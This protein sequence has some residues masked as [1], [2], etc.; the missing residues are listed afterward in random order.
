MN[1]RWPRL[2]ACVAVLSC[3]TIGFAVA[4]I[5]DDPEPIAGVRDVLDPI[6]PAK[7]VAVS[8][9]PEPFHSGVISDGPDPISGAVIERPDPFA[10]AVIDDG[11]DPFSGIIADDPDPFFCIV[12]GPEPVGASIGDGSDVVHGVVTCVGRAAVLVWVA[13]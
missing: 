9:D 5:S 6:D 4:N 2:I 8:E 13:R 7:A 3:L 10:A 11:P 1:A 12:D